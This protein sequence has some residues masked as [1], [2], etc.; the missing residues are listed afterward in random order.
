[1]IGKSHH[2]AVTPHETPA[3][4]QAGDP[5]GEVRGRALQVAHA[6]SKILKG[7]EEDGWP[8]QGNNSTIGICGTAPASKGREIDIERVGVE[9]HR[10]IEAE[11]GPVTVA[12][13]WRRREKADEAAASVDSEIDAGNPFGCVDGSPYA[14]WRRGLLI[15][16]SYGAKPL[17]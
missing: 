17:P 3:A 16:R 14:S 2:R 12:P 1:M 5:A 15:T 4:A 7:V 13:D 9:P 10:H 6:W 8:R 11:T